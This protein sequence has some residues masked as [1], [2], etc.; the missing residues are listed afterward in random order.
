MNK[1]FVK[2]GTRNDI[3]VTQEE[4][5]ED[6]DESDNFFDEQPG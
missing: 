2:K 6:D 1:K 3:L 4:I 5:D